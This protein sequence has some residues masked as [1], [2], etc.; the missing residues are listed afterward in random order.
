LYTNPGD[1]MS[2]GNVEALPLSKYFIQK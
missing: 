2:Q 1:G